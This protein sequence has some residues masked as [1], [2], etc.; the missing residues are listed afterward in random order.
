MIVTSD[1]YAIQICL[2][3][4]TTIYY[5]KINKIMNETSCW[6]CVKEANQKT[7]PKKIQENGDAHKQFNK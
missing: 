1:T 4:N 6:Y 2:I 3:H 5:F 7:K